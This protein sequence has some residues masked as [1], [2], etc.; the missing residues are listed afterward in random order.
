MQGISELSFVSVRENGSFET[1]APSRVH[2][3]WGAMCAAGR[4]FAREAAD[5][6]VATHDLA[7]LGSIVC[8]ISETGIYSG[9]EV[10][11]FTALP[12]ALTLAGGAMAIPEPRTRARAG[13]R[14]ETLDAH[15]IEL[16][17][18]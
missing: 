11:F 17:Q 13:T 10:G 4:G 6:I 1:W 7:F 18:Q 12:G 16:F 5:Y 9:E 15:L 2:T 14:A 8:R 3:E